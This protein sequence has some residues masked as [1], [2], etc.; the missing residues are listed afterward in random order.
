MDAP[1]GDTGTL[2]PLHLWIHKRIYD[3][4]NSRFELTVHTYYAVHVWN[5]R[6]PRGY[7][8]IVRQ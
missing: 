1:H 8:V 6:F 3:M 5:V 2:H 4:G 7:H